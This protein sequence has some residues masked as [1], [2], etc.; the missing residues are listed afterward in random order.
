MPFKLGDLKD[1]GL[2]L[3]GLYEAIKENSGC[4]KEEALAD[5]YALSGINHRKME[6]ILEDAD[7]ITKTFFEENNL[8]HLIA[9]KIIASR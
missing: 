3:K 4:R 1:E 5:A 6:A 2:L 7:A 8:Q 9:G